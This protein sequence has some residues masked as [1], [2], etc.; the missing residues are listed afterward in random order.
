MLLVLLSGADAV[1]CA[2]PPRALGTR[3]APPAMGL[4]DGLAAAFANDDS[5]GERRDAGLTSKKN[6]R[7]I[8]W[9]GPRGQK[10]T[11]QV[12]PGQALRDIARGTG[13][14]IKYNCE[15]GKCKT[16][17]AKVGN[18]RAKICVT[19]APDKDVTIEWGLRQK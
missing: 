18:G 9:V 14:P 1:A 12:V 4:F 19:K 11:S 10:K 3:H 15:N 7:T 17:E 16:C 2:P 6:M 5:L 13:V 8:T